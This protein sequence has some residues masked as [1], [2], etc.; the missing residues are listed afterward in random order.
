MELSDILYSAG[1]VMPLDKIRRN[2]A[3]YNAGFFMCMA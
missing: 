3:S 2:D 1:A